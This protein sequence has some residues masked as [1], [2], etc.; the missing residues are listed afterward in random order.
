MPP[1]RRHNADAA[2]LS[3]LLIIAAASDFSALVRDRPARFACSSNV[4]RMSTFTMLAVR[5]CFV[6]A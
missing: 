1:V 6:A 2:S 5:N 3:L 4:A